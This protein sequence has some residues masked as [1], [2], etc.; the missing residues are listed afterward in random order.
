MKIIIR[1]KGLTRDRA[2]RERI[3]RRLRFAIGR[4][5]DRVERI[6]ITLEDV[7][8]TKG[9]LDQRCR[10]RLVLTEGGDPLL[11]EDTDDDIFVAVDRASK[12]LGRSVARRLKRSRRTRS[13]VS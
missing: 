11:A 2:A 13:P 5:A 7:N 1:T 12:R 10:I 4:F 9:G 8:G 6:S 3:R